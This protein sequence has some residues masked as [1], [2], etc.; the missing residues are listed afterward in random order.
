MPYQTAPAPVKLDPEYFRREALK[1]NSIPTDRKQWL[2]KQ[3]I[4]L[5]SALNRYSMEMQT[6]MEQGAKLD[7]VSD[8]GKWMTTIGGVAAA[9][10]TIYTQIGG[11]VVAIAGSIVSA[12][13]RK[14]DSKALQQLQGQ[15]RKLQL[16]VSQIKN[17]YDNYTSE[18]QRMKLL[19]IL[20]FGTAAFLIRQ[21]L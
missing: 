8:V 4:N 15:A 19:P 13:E 6:L 10:P 9:I 17:Y 16:E 5:Q 20:L 2:D 21:R 11:A 1:F 14:K 7:G 3:I 12:A 18:L